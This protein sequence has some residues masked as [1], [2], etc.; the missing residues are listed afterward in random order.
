MY[1]F[2]SYYTNSHYLNKY[3][4][5]ISACSKHP[6]QSNTYYENH[7][8]V[9][10]SF[11]GSDDPTNI[12]PLTYRQHFIAHLLL[13]KAF[14]YTNIRN[15]LYYFIYGGK[16]GTII[17]TSRA[18]EFAKMLAGIVDSSWVNDGI[19]NYR[20]PLKIGLDLGY[21]AG[22]VSTEIWKNKIF[23]NDGTKNYRIDSNQ[24]SDYLN[25]G[26]IK[27]QL[28]KYKC[29]HV[30][31]GD[32]NRAIPE[33]LLDSFLLENPQ[34]FRGAITKSLYRQKDKI[35]RVSNGDF[36]K[37]VL[38][39]DLE[40]YLSSGWTLG[41]SHRSKTSCAK[42]SN[43]IYLNDQNKRVSDEDL[44]KYLE[45]GWKLGVTDKQKQSNRT[46]T[47]GKIIIHHLEFNKEKR[48]LLQDYQQFEVNGWRKGRHPNSIRAIAAKRS[49]KA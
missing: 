8:I 38:K 37:N 32:I 27:G 11:G 47:L 35:V 45:L 16:Q 12:I 6:L 5:F 34:W 26:Y 42:A 21:Q 13:A 22:R 19:N 3:V 28:K 31:N 1:N 10:R 25:Q 20:L 46:K 2:P 9:P 36:E 18:F 14:P 15:C 30:T 41:R 43:Q 29:I 40:K 39:V 7:H 49:E 4:S 33:D 48:I 44:E 17:K 24:L 23:V